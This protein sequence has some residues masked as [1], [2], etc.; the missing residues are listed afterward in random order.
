M[1][2]TGRQQRWAL[3]ALGLALLTISGHAAAAD[4]LPGPGALAASVILCAA[5]AM[6]LAQRRRSLVGLAGWLLGA[7]AI[8]HVV[9]AVTD[10][11]GHG[12]G[13]VPGPGMIVAHAGAALGVAAVVAWA[14]DLVTAWQRLTRTVLGGVVVPLN[15]VLAAP[16]A[17]VDAS[18]LERRPQRRGHA[19]A[20]RRGPPAG[21]VHSPS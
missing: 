11:H 2:R 8:L 17:P 12:S 16:D 1:A 19:W 6:P 20:G 15:L 4:R 21:L 5:L 9:V 7:Q 14:D 10:G 13:L 18:P 3:I